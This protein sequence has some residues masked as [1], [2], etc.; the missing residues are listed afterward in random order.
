MLIKLY[1]VVESLLYSN[2][3]VQ[4]N[5]NIVGSFPVISLV[6]IFFLMLINF[7]EIVKSQ[8]YIIISRYYV[9]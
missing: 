7:F 9:Y 1:K 8:L 5:I 4:Y 6:S 2:S 3:I